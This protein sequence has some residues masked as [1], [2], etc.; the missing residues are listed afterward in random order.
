MPVRSRE[1]NDQPTESRIRQII[2]N[3]LDQEVR[4]LISGSSSLTGRVTVNEG[5]IAANANS[6]AANVI[7]ICNNQRRG[8]ARNLVPGMQS[9]NAL[10]G[11]AGALVVPTPFTAQVWEVQIV[12]HPIGVTLWSR[13]SFTTEALFDS[14][15]FD[16]VLFDQAVEVLAVNQT[17]GAT[18]TPSTQTFSLDWGVSKTGTL[19]TITSGDFTTV[20]AVTD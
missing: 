1:M 3:I 17:L 8:A 11:G 14:F 2:R 9:S 20:V 6:I 5:D 10:T 12:D 15:L 19:Y 16:A 18:Y 13:Q 7:A 4:R